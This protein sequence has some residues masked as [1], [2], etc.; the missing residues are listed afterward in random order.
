MRLPMWNGI[1]KVIKYGFLPLLAIIGLVG[2]VVSV[3]ISAEDNSALPAYRQ[4]TTLQPDIFS[5]RQLMQLKNGAASTQSP[6]LPYS[7]LFAAKAQNF[8]PISTKVT[9]P[10]TDKNKS[11][12]ARHSNLSLVSATGIIEP[13]SEEIFIG[14]QVSGVITAVYA[15]EG[16]HVKK[17]QPLF[18]IN[19]VDANT[20][21]LSKQ[22]AVRVASAELTQAAQQLSYVENISDPRAV[23]RQEVSDRQDQV[24]IQQAKLQQAE[25]DALQAKANL[26][27]HLVKSPIDGTVIRSDVKVGSYAMSGELATPL[28][29]LGNLRPLTARVSVDEFELSKIHAQPI[30]TVIPKGAPQIRIPATFVRLVPQVAAKQNLTG[31]SGELVDTRVLEMIFRLDQKNPPVFP[32][33]QVDVFIGSNKQKPLLSQVWSI[34]KRR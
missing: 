11:V 30:A 12:D 28:M 19:A 23:S 16:Q 10:Q 31:V 34:A 27:L 15:K 9:P 5:P 24:H 33:Q 13:A 29:T 14:T 6:A 4:P 3:V 1:V 2:A 25:A 26:D 22:A 7:S 18:K 8:T 17:G 21:Y 32:G 20:N